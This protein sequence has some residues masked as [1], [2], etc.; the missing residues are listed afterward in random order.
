MLIHP[1]FQSSEAKLYLITITET[2]INKKQIDV[3]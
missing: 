3:K 1:E 2:S